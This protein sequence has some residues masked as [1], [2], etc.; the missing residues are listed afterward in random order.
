MNRKTEMQLSGNELGGGFVRPAAVAGLFYPSDPEKLTADI[1]GFLRLARD[2]AARPVP[3]AIIV[4]HA[5]YVYSGQ[6]A[7]RA[8]ARVA[9]GRGLIQRVAL[10]GPAHRVSLNGIGLPEADAFAT[11]LGRVRVDRDA[12]TALGLLPQMV[13]GRA[14]HAAEHALEVHLP[15]LQLTLGRDIAVIPLVVGNVVLQQL[16]EVISLLW[17]GPE[18]LIVVSSDLSHYQQYRE[19]VQIDASTAAAVLGQSTSLTHAQACGATPINALMQVAKDR[20]LSVELIDQ[21]NSGDTAGDRARVVGYASFALYA[22]DPDEKDSA[23]TPETVVPQGFPADGGA[24]LVQLARSAI[25][26]ALGQ[27][28]SASLAG[29]WLNAH[30]ATFVTLTIK[31][32]LRG[33][34]GSLVAHRPIGADV[35]EN[36]RAAALRDPRFAPLTT[37]EF[38]ETRVE[39]S[40][41]GLPHPM[42]F[43]SEADLIR[44]IKPGLDGLILESG[45]H[46]A[47]F[48]PQVW[49]Q[50]PEPR[51]FLE[52]L[53][54]KAGLSVHDPGAELRVSRYRVAK[55]VE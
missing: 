50:I 8:Y 27:T 15:F 39:V 28:A 23:D 37:E 16:A 25:G 35:M 34:I 11:P 32:Q 2:Q 30:G 7:A 1:D 53:K 49:K 33:C 6:T 54:Q 19:A 10:L 21:C 22:A 46:R 5:G 51:A 31:G 36:A 45:K 18:T 38:G 14:A 52:A 13:P 3:K 44:Q 20:R 12:I 24:V 41:L 9:N 43:T 48:L 42:R 4:P 47:T 17:G 26:V 29:E 55:F 40:V